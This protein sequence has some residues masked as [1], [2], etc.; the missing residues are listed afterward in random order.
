MV[1]GRETVSQAQGASG[2]VQL[3]NEHSADGVASCLSADSQ[4]H[5]A[6]ANDQVHVEPVDSQSLGEADT[7]IKMTCSGGSQGGTSGDQ[8]EPFPAL[9]RR[10]PSPGPTPF[11]QTVFP[12]S[13]TAAAPDMALMAAARNPPCP[14]LMGQWMHTRLSSIRAGSLRAAPVPSGTEMFRSRL[15]PATTKEQ[16]IEYLKSRGFGQCDVEAFETK[17]EGYASF[18]VKIPFN[19]FKSFRKSIMWPEGVYV[20][21]FYRANSSNTNNA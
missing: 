4:L 3:N 13:S 8:D 9:E 20:R 2:T 16:L 14:A 5:G 6:T 18:R 1:S 11:V 21:K 17:H 12:P 19:K 10:A 15:D 7:V